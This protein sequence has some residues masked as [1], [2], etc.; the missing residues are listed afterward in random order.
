MYLN[1]SSQGIQTITLL[2]TASMGLFGVLVGGFITYLAT[3]RSEEKKAKFQNFQ[4]LQR[5]YSIL[6]GQKERL[7][8]LYKLYY[9]QRCWSIYYNAKHLKQLNFLKRPVNE[10]ILRKMAGEKETEAVKL[11]RSLLKDGE[12]IAESLLKDFKESRKIERQMRLELN[13]V[14]EK[15]WENIG[16]SQALLPASDEINNIS[17]KI[18]LLD[19]ELLMGPPEDDEDIEKW[20]TD[21]IGSVLSHINLKIAP[22]IDELLLFLENKIAE[23]QEKVEKSWWRFW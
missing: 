7:L 4:T 15:M 17:H 2:I 8:D 14:K 11:R 6:Q 12:K 13:R 18:L 23:E 22:T 5:T 10:E 19:L 20:H 1:N 16:L 21:K 3:L 9:E